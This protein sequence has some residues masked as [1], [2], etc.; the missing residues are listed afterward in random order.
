MSADDY[1]SALEEKVDKVHEAEKKSG[2]KKPCLP[3]KQPKG[4]AQGRKAGTDDTIAGDHDSV[5][6]VQHE[7]TTCSL[8]PRHLSAL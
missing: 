7:V 3:S 8:P 5:R 2:A 6:K 4:P 1:I